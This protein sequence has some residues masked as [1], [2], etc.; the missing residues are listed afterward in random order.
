MDVSA[1]DLV[2]REE[3]GICSET[4]GELKED[5]MIIEFSIEMHIG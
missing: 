1:K 3:S 4:L 5:M 2:T